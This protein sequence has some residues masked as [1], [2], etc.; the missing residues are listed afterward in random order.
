MRVFN[1]YSPINERKQEED[2]RIPRWEY[3]DRRR[4]QFA[5]EERFVIRLGEINSDSP[6]LP[7]LKS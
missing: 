4:L 6:S 1:K 5:G 3:S 2:S 7:F